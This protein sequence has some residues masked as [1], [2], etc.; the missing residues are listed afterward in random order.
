MIK[1]SLILPKAQREGGGLD[2]FHKK[3]KFGMIGKRYAFV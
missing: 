3:G 1:V 2:V